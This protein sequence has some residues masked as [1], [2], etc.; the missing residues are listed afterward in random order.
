MAFFSDEVETVFWE[1]ECFYL[2]IEKQQP[3]VF[4]VRKG[5]LR[6][7]TKFTGKHVCQGL[8]FSKV[9]GVK[10]ATLLK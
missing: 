9:A 10:S 3:E 8:F 5:V 4:C 2:N 6:N 1:S 7:F